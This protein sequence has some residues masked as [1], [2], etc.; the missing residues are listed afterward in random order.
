MLTDR[1][2]H[3]GQTF[4]KITYI[5]RH[6]KSLKYTVKR[7]RSLSHSKKHYPLFLF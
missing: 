7:N 1:F 4:E 2:D 3:L 5:T 6:I